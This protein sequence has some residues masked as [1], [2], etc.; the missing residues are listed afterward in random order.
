MGVNDVVC[1]YAS[2]CIVILQSSY[3]L[4]VKQ[5]V[6]KVLSKLLV[7]GK[8]IKT[9]V[10]RGEEGT[11]GEIYNSDVSLNASYINNHGYVLFMCNNFNLF[12]EGMGGTHGL[13]SYM[14]SSSL[15]HDYIECA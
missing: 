1:T 12:T 14:L 4:W 6:I 15:Y 7:K 3:S 13:L 9:G 2:V 8:G 10:G 11:N 5:T